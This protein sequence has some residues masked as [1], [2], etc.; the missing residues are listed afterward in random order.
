[1]V[2]RFRWTQMTLPVMESE[3]IISDRLHNPQSVISVYL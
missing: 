3:A 2:L 1:M